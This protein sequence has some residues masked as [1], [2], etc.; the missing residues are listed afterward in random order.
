MKLVAD[1]IANERRM[2]IAKKGAMSQFCS[3]NT[4]SPSICMDMDQTS[5]R[6]IDIIQGISTSWQS[7]VNASRQSGKSAY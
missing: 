2:K 7:G 5:C 3:C 1:T 4:C 6:S